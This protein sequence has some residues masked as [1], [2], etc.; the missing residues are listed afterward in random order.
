MPREV[1]SQDARRRITS[2][3]T[4]LSAVPGYKTEANQHEKP[5]WNVVNSKGSLVIVT[6]LTSH[7]TTLEKLLLQ[8]LSFDKGK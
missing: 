1:L 7:M 4:Y 5:V 3:Y 8:K 2:D 6:A